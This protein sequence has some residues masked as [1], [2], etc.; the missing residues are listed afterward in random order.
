MSAGGELMG[1]GG[2]L[3]GVGGKSPEKRTLTSSFRDFV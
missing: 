1:V 3:M 2:E